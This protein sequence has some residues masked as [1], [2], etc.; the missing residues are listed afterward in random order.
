MKN[1][2]TSKK[3]ATKAAKALR[4]HHEPENCKAWHAAAEAVLRAY[5]KRSG[6]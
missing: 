4:A 2:R 3:I 5:L 1:E 6:R